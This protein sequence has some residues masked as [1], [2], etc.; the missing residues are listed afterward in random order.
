MSAQAT[1]FYF[2]KLNQAYKKCYVIKSNY[3]FTGNLKT[4]DQ[5]S[6]KL[7]ESCPTEYHIIMTRYHEL[8]EIHSKIEFSHKKGILDFTNPSDRLILEKRS[9]ARSPSLY[10]YIVKLQTE[11]PN[12]YKSIFSS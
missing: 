1:K 4:L 8:L 5:I 7:F 12:A 11:N 3:D 9:W 10:N 2:A 6:G